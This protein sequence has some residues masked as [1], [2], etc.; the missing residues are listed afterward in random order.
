MKGIPWKL[1]VNPMEKIPGI[2]VVMNH[3]G[4]FQDDHL[5]FAIA[6]DLD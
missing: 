4:R 6:A 1:A 5:P 2:P 3:M